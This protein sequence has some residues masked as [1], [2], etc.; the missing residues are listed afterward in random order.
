MSRPIRL[1]DAAKVTA[2]AV[3]WLPWG[4]VHSITGSETLNARFP[5]QWFQVESGLHY[6]WH[7]HYDPTIGRYTQPDPLGLD[8]GVSLYAYGRNSPQAEIDPTGENPIALLCLRYPRVCGQVLQC[9]RDPKSCKPK[10]CG[11]GSQLYKPLCSVPK[12]NPGD[13]KSTLDFKLAA[14]EACFTLR[15]AVARFCYGG[16]DD[17]HGPPIHEVMEKVAGCRAQCIA[18]GN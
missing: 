17:A 14:A 18:R 15:V 3:E 12:C 10:F 1:T 13:H 8:A 5:G 6:N 4:G 11:A 2:W 7:R 9:I 16:I